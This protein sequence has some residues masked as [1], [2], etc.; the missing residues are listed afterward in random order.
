MLYLIGAH[1]QIVENTNA[2]LKQGF[3]VKRRLDALRAAIKKLRT[4]QMLQ[5]GNRPGYGRLRHREMLG[6][7]RHAASF[8]DCEK[9][10]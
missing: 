3:A 4:E 10:I 8:G 2:S 6:R 9:H 5:I 7:L 1:P